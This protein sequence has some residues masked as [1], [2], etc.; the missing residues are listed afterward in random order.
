MKL[1]WNNFGNKR[2]PIRLKIYM[3]TL[4]DYAGTDF[5]NHFFNHYIYKSDMPDMKH[6]LNTVGVSLTQD[7]SKYDFGAMVKNGLITENTI[8]GSSAYNAGV[9]NGDKIIKVG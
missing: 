3:I 9:E 5:G 8:M 4:N 7:N 1:V 6:L 2:N